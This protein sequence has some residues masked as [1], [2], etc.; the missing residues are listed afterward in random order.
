M[1]PTLASQIL[2]SQFEIPFIDKKLVLDFIEWN[3]YQANGRSLSL[4]VPWVIPE[5]HAD[6]ATR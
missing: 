6:C 4:N 2:R 5:R 3:I 1:K